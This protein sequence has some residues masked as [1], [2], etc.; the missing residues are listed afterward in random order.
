[1][2]RFS[3]LLMFALVASVSTASKIPPQMTLT[4]QV[5]SELGRM[6]TDLRSLES[7][8]SELQSKVRDARGRVDTAIRVSGMIRSLDRR[9]EKLIDQLKPYQ[10]IPKVRT[11][12]RNLSRN[13]QRIHEQ[14][15]ELRKKS[16]H[17]ERNVLKPLKQRLVSIEQTVMGGRQKLAGYRNGV[18]VWRS[19]LA[20]LSIQASRLPSVS[21]KV[22]RCVGEINPMLRSA[23]RVLHTATENT[24]SILRQVNRLGRMFTA[25]QSVGHSL[26]GFEKKIVPAEATVGKLDN[27]LG[28]EL[29][30]KLPFSK[31]YLRFTIREILEMPGQIV[32][33]VLKPFEA[34]ADKALQ[35]LLKKLNLQIKPPAGLAELTRELDRVQTIHQAIDR[36]GSNL[37]SEA[38]SQ[39]ESV[40]RRAIALRTEVR[41]TFAA[42]QHETYPIKQ[43]PKPKNTSERPP[44]AMFLQLS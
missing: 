16:D 41:R 43:T 21:S 32:G 10:S 23:N 35:P 4:R 5:D 2:K 9:V 44:V 31:K 26:A 20:S 12:A 7:Q 13:L 29:K 33:V 34:L 27:T 8:L 40:S 6:Q 36:L 39:L 28:K 30:I 19:E 17:C 15:H 25:Y 14:L 3:I 37:V 22:D 42:A 38:L 1:M 18:A 11:F 24:V